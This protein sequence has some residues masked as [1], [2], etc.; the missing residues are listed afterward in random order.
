MKW[1][2]YFL[3]FIFGSI[4]GALSMHIG[5]EEGITPDSVVTENESQF[6]ISEFPL[7]EVSDSTLSPA[8]PSIN[9]SDTT[10]P[11]QPNNPLEDQNV[12]YDFPMGEIS[13]ADSVV[14]YDPGAMGQGTGDEPDPEFQKPDRALGPPNAITEE[15]TGFVSLGRGGYI[16]LKF[17]DN[18]LIDGPGSD[19][20][21]FETN[22]NPEDFFVWISRDGK[23]FLPLGE[24]KSDQPNIDIQSKAEPGVFYSYVRIRDD[25]DQGEEMGPSLGADIDAVAAIHSAVRKKIYSDQLFA[26]KTPNLSDQA[27]EILAGIANT[28]RQYLPATV[29]IEAH[30]DSWGAENYN[31]ILSQQQAYEIRNY[32]LDREQLREVDY[33]VIGW[34][35]MVPSVSNDTEEGRYENRRVEILIKR[36]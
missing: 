20:T 33:T 32:F 21:I 26:G 8:E 19:L 25:P 14:M 4:S 28:I 12:E 5:I 30:T 34:G 1:L 11:V 6:L 17:T 18:V 16:I 2:C 31:L 9:L 29:S 10:H 7:S 15:D 36:N 3:L 27:P 23:I 22:S 35:E 13:F 24:V